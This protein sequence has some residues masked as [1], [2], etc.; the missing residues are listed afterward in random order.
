MKVRLP[1]SIYRDAEI[2][3]DADEITVEELVKIL[4]EKIGRDLRK[5]IIRNGDLSPFV[6]VFINGKNVRHEKGLKTIVKKGD[7]VSLVPAVA[8]G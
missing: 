7:E 6:N 8:G 3:I 5:L 1:S 2:E 4:S